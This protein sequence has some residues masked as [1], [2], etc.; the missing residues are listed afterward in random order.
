MN[1]DSALG[2]IEERKESDGGDSKQ[3]PAALRDIP[4]E[5]ET[6]T[7]RSGSLKLAFFFTVLGGFVCLTNGFAAILSNSSFDYGSS[8][9][10]N[11]CGILVF[12]LGIGAVLGGVASIV[13]R[14]VSPAFGGAV[15]VMAGG[16]YIGFWL[17][18]A[19]IITLFM[20]DEDL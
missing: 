15:L 5:I 20:S 6:T 9:P 2:R 11:Y 12:V 1:Q 16:T 14:R 4:G 19:A 3:E 18:L 10:V 13:L 17:G 8:S 7:S